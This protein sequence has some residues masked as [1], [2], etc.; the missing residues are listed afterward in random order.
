MSADLES[1]ISGSQRRRPRVGEGQEG[2]GS[3]RGGGKKRK[4]GE[5][6]VGAR[7]DADVSCGKKRAGG[8]G[9]LRGR[10]CMP[11]PESPARP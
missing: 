9:G 11:S 2:E 1:G 6:K 8:V 5:R 4:K 10:R 7:V 3:R